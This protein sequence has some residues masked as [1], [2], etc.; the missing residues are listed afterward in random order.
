[1]HEK[2]IMNKIKTVSVGVIIEIMIIIC[3]GY[4]NLYLKPLYY[5]FFY[6][7]LYGIIFSFLLPLFLLRKEE[8]VFEFIGFKFPGKKQI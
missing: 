8:N 3:V 6:N 4:A 5:F 1:M 7:I 2:N